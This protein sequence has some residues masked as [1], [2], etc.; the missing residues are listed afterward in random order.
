MTGR[1]GFGYDGFAF[2]QRVAFQW[3]WGLV[4]FNTETTTHEEDW[5]DE[6]W[7]WG[8]RSMLQFCI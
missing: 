7:G 2:H 3:A 6:R 1:V 5:L 8:Q 4:K